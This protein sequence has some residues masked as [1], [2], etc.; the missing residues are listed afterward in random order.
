MLT[1]LTKIVAPFFVLALIGLL[2]TV[3]ASQSSHSESRTSIHSDT[4]S[5]TQENNN[6]NWH[7][8]DN[9]IDQHVSIRG[10]VEFTDDYTDIKSITAGG[11]IR[12]VVAHGG[13]TRKF[14]AS[15]EAGG[16]KRAYWVN[17]Q[18]APF[19]DDARA[20]LAKVLDDTVRKSGYDAPA[21]VQRILGQSGPRGV[22]AEISQLGSDYVKRIYFDALLDQGNL[23]ADTARLALQQAGREMSSDYEKAQ[24]LIKLSERYLTSDEMRTIYLEGVNTLH[25]NYEK[26]RALSALLKQGNLGRDSL[27]FTIKSAA[28]INS[29]YERAQLLVKIA[30]RFT[31][32][33]LAQSAYLEAVTSIGSDYEK[34][35][36]LAAF[37]KR[38]NASRDT[39]LFMLKSASSIASDYEK[40]QLLLKVA[41]AGSS[42]DAVRNAL[43]DAARSIHSEYER[44]RVLSAVIK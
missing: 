36:V 42:D 4:D 21:R 26:G 27:R 3:H 5:T 20:W 35:R 2:P 38:N 16:L 41:A 32:D 9:D 40:A 39:L 43:I 8:V 34:G 25:S 22:L 1:R 28:T 7:H 17:G 24:L 11:S 14:E 12:I 19:N 10:R 15:N 18:S 44:E 13:V 31:L 23:D 29:D 33:E 37:L 30:D 6:W